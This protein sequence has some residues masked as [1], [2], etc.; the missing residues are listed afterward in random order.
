MT[1]CRRFV[2]FNSYFASVEQQE[3]ADL[4]GRPIAVASVMANSSCCI[5]A[6]INEK[7]STLKPAH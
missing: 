6:S 3:N 5:A 7:K 4:R 2:D 1:L